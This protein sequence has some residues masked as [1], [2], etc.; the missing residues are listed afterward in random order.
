MKIDGYQLVGESLSINNPYNSLCPICKE[1]ADHSCRCCGPH[2]YDQLVQGHGLGCKNGHRWSRT[3]VYDP[4]LSKAANRLKRM[5]QRR[6][7][8][9]IEESE[10]EE[11]KSKV[12]DAA[13]DKAVS[14]ISRE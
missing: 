5:K 4:S 1:P 12:K 2:T 10:G 6:D 3:I 13:L 7:P 9:G 11:L 14:L 8:E